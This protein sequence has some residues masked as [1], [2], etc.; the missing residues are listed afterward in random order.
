MS[1]QNAGSQPGSP[2]MNS[3]NS[4]S[5]SPHNTQLSDLLTKGLMPRNIAPNM[6][7]RRKPPPSSAPGVTGDGGLQDVSG[8]HSSTPPSIDHLLGL[9]P[10]G[11]D[12]NSMPRVPGPGFDS[13]LFQQQSS[14]PLSNM[15]MPSVGHSGSDPSMLYQQAGYGSH[16]PP[17]PFMAAATNGFGS[18]SFSGLNGQTSQSNDFT[19]AGGE[20]TN[21]PSLN[22]L[23]RMRTPLVLPPL[24]GPEPIS[25][26]GSDTG[27]LPSLTNSPHKPMFSLGAAESSGNG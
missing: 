17:N 6:V 26:D 1:G 19:S 14:S 3:G 22:H 13:T 10:Q 24:D 11:Y 4:L 20:P 23:L 7:E 21:L 18:S 25:R 9:M 27:S 12:D 16:Y 15:A 5:Q 2:A 8:N